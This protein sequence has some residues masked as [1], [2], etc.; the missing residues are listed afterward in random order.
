[1][2]GLEAVVVYR[3]F[4]LSLDALFA[5]VRVVITPVII[6]LTLRIP[7]KRKHHWAFLVTNIV[8]IWG[9]GFALLAQVSTNAATA[10]GWYYYSSFAVPSSVI[11]LFSYQFVIYFISPKPSRW[12]KYVLIGGYGWAAATVWI[13]LLIGDR[14]F[15]QTIPTLT[16]FG[17]TTGP[18]TSTPYLVPSG[19]DIYFT[20]MVALIFYLLIRHY[21][22]EKSPLK[23]G[24]TIYIM[25]GLACVFAGSYQA[26]IA[27]DT[28]AHNLPILQNLISIPGDLVLLLG[29]RKKGFYSVTP[30]AETATVRTPIKYPLQDGHSYLVRDPKAAFEAFSELVRSGRE[31]LLITR[32]FPEDVRK[33]YGIQTTPIRWLAEEKGEDVIS[34]GDLLGLSLTVKDFLQKATKPVVMLHG[35]EYLTTYNGFTPVLRL[36]QGLNETNATRRGILLLPLVPKSLD[37]KD[38]AL[39]IAETTPLPSPTVGLK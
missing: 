20:A 11:V 28:G 35:I 12:Q 1:V 24:Q 34:S 27:R 36:I 18:G 7:F 2:I 29:L 8:F 30:T 21:Q 33:D 17:W 4:G 26:V 10:F 25:I 16:S 37:E 9:V 32:I 23:R 14:N 5:L 39:L 31:G 3:I 19:I 13:P 22:Y 15:F 38:E 6:I